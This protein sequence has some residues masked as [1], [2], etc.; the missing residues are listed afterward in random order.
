M[1][2]RETIRTNIQAIEK[3][4]GGNVEDN[5]D[6]GLETY[7]LSRDR[8]KI[9]KLLE[10]RANFDGVDLKKANQ[11]YLQGVQEYEASN[12]LNKAVRNDLLK[13]GIKIIS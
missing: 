2:K 1:P 12:N 8:K 10:E 5:L 11:L 9:I 4:F 6:K 13:E 3:G 7:S